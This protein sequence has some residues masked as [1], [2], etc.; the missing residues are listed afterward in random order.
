MFSFGSPKEDDTLTITEGTKKGTYFKQNLL[1]IQ[2]QMIAIGEMVYWPP[3]FF[4]FRKKSDQSIYDF[5]WTPIKQYK[6]EHGIP[7]ILREK[8][9]G[10][11]EPQAHF[12]LKP[13]NTMLTIDTTYT[14]GQIIKE[15]DIFQKD[16]FPKDKSKGGKR[17]YKK[18]TSRRRQKKSRKGTRRR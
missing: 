10:E 16:K 15:F 1:G 7:T 14:S 6:N 12:N 8:Y 17:T 13:Y 18:R 4:L 3:E 11:S 5:G 2:L 9:N